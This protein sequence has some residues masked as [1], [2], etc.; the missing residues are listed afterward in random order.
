MCTCEKEEED[1][2]L[3][4]PRYLYTHPLSVILLSLPPHKGY[5]ELLT[6]TDLTCFPPF[7]FVRFICS[8]RHL[9]S[10]LTITRPLASS[11]TLDDQDAR[12]SNDR[13]LRLVSEQVITFLVPLAVSAYPCVELAAYA[14]A[15]QER[16]VSVFL[17]SNA[18]RP[19]RQ[20]VVCHLADAAAVLCRSII[21]MAA[22]KSVRLAV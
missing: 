8:P 16:R 13:P 2:R 15:L 17:R 18:H 10:V 1:K 3:Q 19:P 20:V 11:M 14:N 9:A 22:L 6:Q 5:L 7:Y 21:R 4:T 12:E